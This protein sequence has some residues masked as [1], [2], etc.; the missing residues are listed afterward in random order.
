MLFRGSFQTW[1]LCGLHSHF[2]GADSYLS[3]EAPVVL[4]PESLLWSFV[5]QLPLRIREA[6][7]A[8]M[9]D[10]SERESLL[11]FSEV[12]YQKKG[13]LDR[14]LI[15]FPCSCQNEEWIKT[16]PMIYE[17]SVLQSSALCIM[18][19]WLLVLMPLSLFWCSDLWGWGLWKL[20]LAIAHVKLSGANDA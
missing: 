7:Y 17:G 12:Y 20:P 3:R 13:A 8:I 5:F 16:Y 4:F 9:R 1:P 10:S 2:S 15:L 14:G 6:F 11:S 18:A 19:Q